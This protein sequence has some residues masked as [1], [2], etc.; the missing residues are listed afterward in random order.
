MG[1]IGIDR[2]SPKEGRKDTGS[3][4]QR[5]ANLF[6]E[7]DRLAL[8]VTPEAT[9]SLRTEW[10]MGF[11]HVA[12]KANVPICLGYLDYEHKVAG[13]G[14]PIFISGDIDADLRKVMAFY[15]P[16]RGKYPEK[17]SID[18]RYLPE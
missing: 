7:Q 9:R 12:K 3:Y 17:F 11:Y 1:G 10:K 6:K 16:I 14:G 4:I 5:M 13:V 18:E 15:Q 8:L 2:R